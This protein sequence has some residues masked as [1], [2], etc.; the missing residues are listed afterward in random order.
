MDILEQIIRF[1]RRQ[2]VNAYLVGGSVRDQVLGRPSMRD[3]DIA[4]EGN[5][6][7]LAR[8]FADMMGGAFYLMDAEHNV[9][10][11][12]LGK[13]YVDFSEL[14]GT[15]EQDLA[16]RD[17]TINAMARPL[18][19]SSNDTRNV[20][21][22]F[23]GLADLRAR[24]IRAVSD[25]SFHDPVRMLRAVRIAGDLEMTVEPHTESLIERDAAMLARAPMERA[26]DEFF[27]ILAQ[28]G[29]VIQLR[30]MHRLGLLGSLLPEVAALQGIRQSAP[31]TFDVFEHTLHCVEELVKI[32]ARDYVEIAN[33]ELAAELGSHFNQVISGDRMRGPLLRLAALL[34]DIGKPETLSVDDEGNIH[35][36]EHEMRGA[37]MAGDI[38]R[39]LRFSND[40]IEIVTRTIEH[41]LRPPQLARAAKVSNRAVYRFFRDTGDEGIEICVLSLADSRGKSALSLEPD[42]DEILRKMLANLLE[43]YYRS[44]ETV[45]APPVLLD[46]R[47]LMKELGVTPGPRVGQ[48][49]EAIREAQADGQVNS[50]EEA[51]ALARQILSKE[52]R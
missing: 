12:I 28:P 7:A 39:R 27:K 4:L 41:H 47:T 23:Q 24:Q 15:L 5:A 52:G 45:I 51:L 20:I 17:L 16:T 11:V 6:S 18:G 21:D 49:L 48:L 13:L 29:V 14:R 43:K 26:R 22:P 25:R 38:L 8:A 40:E 2:N 30:Y 3:I 19:E 46:G 33:G 1:L 50:R 32:Q 36:Y 42:K 31:H 35:F 37:K 10:R 34:H 9:A 44:P